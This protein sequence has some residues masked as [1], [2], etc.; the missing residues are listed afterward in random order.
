MPTGMSPAL[1]PG[2]KQWEDDGT[3]PILVYKNE[4]REMDNFYNGTHA[5]LDPGLRTDYTNSP[6]RGGGPIYQN[7]EHQ[8]TTENDPKLPYDFRCPDG[9]YPCQLTYSYDYQDYDDDSPELLK[10]VSTVIGILSL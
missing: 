7:Y 3:T 1:N 6:V 9:V 10:P 5:K 8:R 4:T 2:T